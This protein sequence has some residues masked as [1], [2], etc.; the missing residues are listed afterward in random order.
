[1]MCLCQ[2]CLAKPKDSFFQVIFQACGLSTKA[3]LNMRGRVFL[4]KKALGGSP[5]PRQPFSD[6]VCKTIMRGANNQ[7]NPRNLVHRIEEVLR[8]IQKEAPGFL[9]LL[10]A[11]YSRKMPATSDS[12]TTKLHLSKLVSGGRERGATIHEEEPSIA[13]E[14]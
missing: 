9:N 3:M 6:S 13:T 4:R 14:G 1:M 2:H 7:N 5:C 10:H 11:Q 8:K 12:S